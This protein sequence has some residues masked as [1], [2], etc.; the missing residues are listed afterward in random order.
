[1]LDRGVCPVMTS[2]CVC[3]MVYHPNLFSVRTVHPKPDNR[4]V[5]KASITGSIEHL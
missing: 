2:M 4:D 3:S 1:M 5:M